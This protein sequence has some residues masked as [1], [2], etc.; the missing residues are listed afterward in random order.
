M[1]MIGWNPDIPS[2]EECRRRVGNLSSTER[3][4]L[5]GLY[6]GWSL[7]AISYKLGFNVDDGRAH[8]HR[9]FDTLDTG[10]LT[11][12]LAMRRRAEVAA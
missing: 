7:K 5:E 4:I 9:V 8:L 2:A 11:G 1:T 10:A 3:E 6:G 12:A